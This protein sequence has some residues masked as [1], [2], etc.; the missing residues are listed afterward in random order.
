MGTVRFSISGRPAIGNDLFFR[1]EGNDR[2]ALELFNCVARH[3]PINFFKS[4]YL[5]TAR[6][7]IAP[8]Q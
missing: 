5:C 1:D 7:G 4:P 8:Y 6:L 3:G 2:A